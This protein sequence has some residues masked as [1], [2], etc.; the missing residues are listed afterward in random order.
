MISKERCLINAFSRSIWVEFPLFDNMFSVIIP[1]HNSQ[2]Y[3]ASAIKSVVEQTLQEWELLVVD[4]ASEDDTSL[5]VQ[6]FLKKDERIKYVKLDIPSGSPAMP[7]N[8][9]VKCAKGR[10]IAFLDSDDVWLPNKLE[11]QLSMFEKYKDMAICFSNYEKMS[12]SG[13]RHKRVVKAP[14]M[15]DYE[16]LLKGNVIGGLTAVYDTAKV[17]KRFFM[18]HPHEDYILWLGILK[19]GYVAR[20]TNTVEALYRVRRHSVSSNKLKAMSWQWSIY[21]NVEKIGYWRAV[22]YFLFYAYK[23]FKKR[24]I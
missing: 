17:G 9:G 13:E 7:R 4:D 22:Y 19:Q 23:A 14:A 15:A 1:C 8:E 24:M 6:D 2:E 21:R 5:I 10:Y 20:N 11:H 12:E 16:Y 3:I 18:N